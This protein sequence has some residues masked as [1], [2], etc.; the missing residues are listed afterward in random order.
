MMRVLAGAVVYLLLLVLA[1]FWIA[2][3]ASRDHNEP[4]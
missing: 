4:L 1:L 3:S 2:R